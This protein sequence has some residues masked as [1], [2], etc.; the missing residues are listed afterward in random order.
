MTPD[1][2]IDFLIAL[3]HFIFDAV[4]VVAVILIPLALI[5]K[6]RFIAA[7]G[8]YLAGNAFGLLL[9]LT[10]LVIVLQSGGLFWTII[11]ILTIVGIV[12][13]A[14]VCV[15]IQHFWAGL[16]DLVIALV[17]GFGL[18]LLGGWIASMAG[19]KASRPPA[20]SE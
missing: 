14:F 17:G 12:P 8:Y 11:G 18:R 15:F 6:T 5:P 1:R 16:L 2:I 19:R 3:G 20:T 4:V 9:W 7:I 13:I 10:S